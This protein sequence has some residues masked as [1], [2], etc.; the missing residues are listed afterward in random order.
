VIKDTV[1][2]STRGGSAEL[3]TIKGGAHALI[4]MGD[5]DTYTNAVNKHI[6]TYGKTVLTVTGEPPQQLYTE[7]PVEEES[8]NKNQFPFFT[9]NR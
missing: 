6:D 1:N 9:W 2:S 4:I 8:D 3:V 7:D 5:N